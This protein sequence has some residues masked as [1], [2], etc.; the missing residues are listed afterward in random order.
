AN[1]FSKARESIKNKLKTIETGEERQIAEGLV[2]ASDVRR[3]YCLGRVALE[4]ARILDRQGDHLASSKRYDQATESF[5]KVIDSMERE[6]EKK[7]LLPIIYLCQA[8]ERMMMAEARVSPTLYDEAAEL[9]LKAEKHALD[10]PTSFLVQAHSSFCKALEAG[11]RFERTLDT[12]MYS[13]AKRHI[14]AATNHYLRA[15][16]QT[17]SDYA[18]ATNRLIDAYMYIY[19]AQSDTDPAQKARSYQMA[20]RLLQA[21]AGTF[22]KAK[23]PEKSEEVRR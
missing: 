13:T 21:S 20:E 7:E 2:K 17:F 16:Y 18:T 9:F 1:L 22:I 23:H 12:T 10:Q 15:G 11:V 4:E 14:V 3:E 8:W 5:Q 19:R 6:P